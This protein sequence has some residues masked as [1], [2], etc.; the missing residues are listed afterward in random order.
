MKHITKKKPPPSLIKWYGN[1]KG[2]NRSYKKGSLDAEILEDIRKSLL[3]EQGY[4]CCYTGKR[5]D[6]KSSHIEHIKPQ[7]VS[8]NNRKNGI[9]DYDD[10]KYQNML[11]AYPLKLFVRDAKTGKEKHV[12]CA[13][14][15]EARDDKELPIS[16]LQKNC[17][18]R[19]SFNALGEIFPTN[20]MDAAAENTIKLLKLYHKDLIRERRTVIA[21]MLSQTDLTEPQAKKAVGRALERDETN[22][23]KPFCLVLKF[24]CELRLK[25]IERDQN[26]KKYSRQV[27]K[28]K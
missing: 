3:E 26:A 21:A 4:L 28:R 12:K 15:A 8:R 25:K 19:F 13:F 17:E 27:N 6:L 2:L 1:E 14:G 7:A 23:F 11:A 16:P 20:K 5:I 24:A 22:R 9:E 10:V 18:Q